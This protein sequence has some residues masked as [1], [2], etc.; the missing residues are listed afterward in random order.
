MIAVAA[1]TTRRVPWAP[2]VLALW[3]VLFILSGIQRIAPAS[4]WLVVD[5]VMVADTVLGEDPDM[6]VRRVVKQPFL[7]HWTADVEK[8][9]LA[10]RFEHV[11]SA[12][13]EAL[14]R[15]DNDLPKRLKL[16]YWSA[17]YCIPEAPG[18]YRVD[19]EWMIMLP[20]GLTKIVTATSN[21][22]NVTD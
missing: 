21:T 22:F 5:S 2:I 14:Y 3:T 1:A 11:C 4:N 9:T 20:G 6:V 7:G 8:E 17:P 19:T 16:S 12:N 18:R 13:G 15:P 10:G